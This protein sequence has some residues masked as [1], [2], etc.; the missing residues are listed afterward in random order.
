MTSAAVH[1]DTSSPANAPPRRSSASFEAPRPI[2]VQTTS[3]SGN[4]NSVLAQVQRKSFKKTESGSWQVGTDSGSVTVTRSA[5]TDRMKRMMVMSVADDFNQRL[6]RSR[7]LRTAASDER[8]F[9][10]LVKGARATTE[11][12]ILN[13]YSGNSIDA[14][15]EQG[16]DYWVD[17]KTLEAQIRAKEAVSKRREEFKTRENAFVED[18]LRKEIAAP[19]KNNLISVI[20]VGIGLI[21]AL[22]AAF[23]GLLELNEPASIAS[24]PSEL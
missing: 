3:T 9:V 10:P 4:E 7:K 19:Y 8:N 24:F 2:W 20:V 13:A 17:P 12:S 23:P 21:G 5:K 1:Q 15:R 16:E 18:R 14:K 11:E 22:F 6:R